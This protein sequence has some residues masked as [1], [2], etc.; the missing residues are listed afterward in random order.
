M[1]EQTTNV[2]KK[3]L[4]FSFSKIKPK[5]SLT[6]KSNE[7]VKAFEITAT[8]NLKNDEDEKCELIGSIEGKKVKS[9]NKSEGDE[10]KKPLIIPCQKNLLNFNPKLATTATSAE[11]LEIIKELIKDTLK[12][13]EEQNKDANL[14]VEMTN[15]QKEAEIVEDPNYE[16]IGIEQFGMAAL[17][18]MGWNEKTGIGLN[19]KRSIVVVEPELRPR[20]KKYYFF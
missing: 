9:L 16:Q 15:K 5:T 6:I 20:G 18:G 7:T 2:E 8:K 17:R 19:N 4:T 14:T 12:N 1:N 3:T 13:K 10:K 11:D